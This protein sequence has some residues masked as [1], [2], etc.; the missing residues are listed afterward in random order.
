MRDYADAAYVVLSIHDRDR[1]F[2]WKVCKNM[3]Q[4]FE[5][6]DSIIDC[7]RDVNSGATRVA[8]SSGEI[9]FR[10]NDPA[11]DFYLIESGE[12]RLYEVAQCGI[13]RLLYILGATEWFGCASLAG[14]SLHGKLTISAVNSVVMS[15]PIELFRQMLDSHHDIALHFLDDMSRHL[16]QART[17]NAMFLFHNCRMRIIETLLKFKDSPAARAVPDGVELRITHAELA[18]AIGAARETVSTCLIQLRQENLVHTIRSRIIFDPARLRELEADMEFNLG[19]RVSVPPPPIHP[20]RVV[21]SGFLP[22]SHLPQKHLF[23]ASPDAVADESIG[24][25]DPPDQPMAA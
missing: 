14:L 24:D 11:L 5:N 13:R 17:E 23:Q 15:M 1:Y 22:A 7:F 8:F 20:L 19:M 18:G 10:P 2:L 21:P 6:G 25:A 3:N 9:V 16:Y 4:F 12:I